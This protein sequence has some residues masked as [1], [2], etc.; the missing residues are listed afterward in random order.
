MPLDLSTG[1]STAAASRAAQYLTF[2][3][4]FS[5]CSPPNTSPQ[6]ARFL[7][8]SARFLTIG[9]ARA[10]SARDSAALNQNLEPYES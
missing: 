7:T 9:P 10:Q 3:R 8:Y 4:P 2:G 5:H 1:L 6:D